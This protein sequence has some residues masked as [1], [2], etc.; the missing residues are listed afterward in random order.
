MGLCDRLQ[1]LFSINGNSFQRKPKLFYSSIM[2]L[3][4]TIFISEQTAENRFEALL[5]IGDNFIPKFNV[6]SYDFAVHP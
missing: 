2:F 1:N 6:S 3:F 4:E 5:K